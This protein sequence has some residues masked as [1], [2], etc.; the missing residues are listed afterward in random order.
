VRAVITVSSFLEII[1][2]KMRERKFWGEEERV[3]HPL[4]IGVGPE[5]SGGP[6][7]DFKNL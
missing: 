2:S 3:A 7:R 5:V 6:E 4:E 1:T